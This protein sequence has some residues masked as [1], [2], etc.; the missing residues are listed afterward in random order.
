[1][2]HV[3]QPLLGFVLVGGVLGG[4]FGLLTLIFWVWMLIDAIKNPRL[5][6][7]QRVI[8]VLVIF[9]LP[10]L[11]SIIYYVAGRSK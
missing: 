11:G 2:H 9:F 1:M 7:T 5:D 3:L 10:C 4:L 8:W 6:G